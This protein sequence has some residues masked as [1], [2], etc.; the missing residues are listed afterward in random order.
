MA[1]RTSNVRFNKVN[2]Q[3]F[4]DQSLSHFYVRVRAT[5]TLV[6]KADLNLQLL[7]VANKARTNVVGDCRH[8]L[9]VIAVVSGGGKEDEE[10]F[11]TTLL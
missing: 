4:S 7:N 11:S 9:L 10:I 8:H 5:I 6:N 1:L 3:H 2:L